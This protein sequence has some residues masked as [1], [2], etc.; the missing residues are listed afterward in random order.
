MS[1]TSTMGAA[2]T[3]GRR[4]G[5]AI[6]TRR[7][8]QAALS[9]PETMLSI[10]LC[11]PLVLGAVSLL[12][13]SV[14]EQS[15]S[16][17]TLLMEQEAQYALNLIANVAQLAGHHDPLTIAP[18]HT[19][20]RLQ[21]MDDATLAARTAIEA[22]RSG[23]G[24]FGSDVL[25]VRFSGGKAS[26]YSPL[27]CAG[28]PVH[29]GDAGATGA[30][31]LAADDQGYSIFYVARG[32]GGEYELR[33]KYRT[34]GGWDSEA[35]VQGVGSFQVLYGLD[36][37]GDGLPEQFLR[38]GAITDE[39]SS[40]TS[41]TSG[42]PGASGT[43]LW[44]RVVALRIALLLHSTQRVQQPLTPVTW[45]LFGDAYSMHHASIDRGTQLS[46]EDF[47]GALRYRL[48]RNYEQLI[49]IRNPSSVAA[50]E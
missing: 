29:S 43:S 14:N 15:L 34:P 18:L 39:I 22:G 16:H 4:R 21:G 35:L 32:P 24:P 27:N 47:T 38:A 20:P 45:N 36:R 28:M 11:M 49:F 12:C 17:Q 46:D 1:P 26:G 10:G 6:T 44:N 23:P 42:T 41:G 9:L 8:W 48:R 40:G 7:R 5:Q 25:I 13:T 33:C 2:D 50:S 37:D 30:G 31:D 3:Q 19:Q